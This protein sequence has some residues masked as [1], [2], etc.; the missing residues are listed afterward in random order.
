MS[1][2]FGKK[3]LESLDYAEMLKEIEKRKLTL[4]QIKT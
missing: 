1:P 4:N 2:D 3:G